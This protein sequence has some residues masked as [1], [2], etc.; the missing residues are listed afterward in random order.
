MR[1]S[2][3]LALAAAALFGA[4]TPASKLLLGSVPPF[5][6]AG[7]LYLG[8]GLATAPRALRGGFVSRIRAL[9]PRNR[10]FVAGSIVFGG[11]LGPVFLLFGL[12]FAKSASVSLWL[13][14][15]L[16]MTALVGQFLFKDRMTRAS[17][18]AAIGI[19]AASL[20]LSFEGGSAGL[21]GGLFVAA[22]CLAWGFDNHFTA[23]NDGLGPEESTFVKGLV[24]GLVNL[25][26]GLILGAH[27]VADF[28]TVL[29]A[30]AIGALSYGISIALYIAA[31]QGLG[32]SRAQLFFS[33]SPIFGI[34]LAA[35][36]LGES[37]TIAQVAAFVV[38]LLS[39]AAL[40]S[41]RHV[42]GHEHTATTHTHWHR[43]GEAH[44]DHVHASLGMF[45]RLFG[46]SHE[47][48]HEAIAHA[49][50]HVSDIHHRHR[51]EGKSA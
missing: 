19:L 36:I 28:R 37:F 5:V 3:L 12:S 10:A 25:A 31:A 27:G 44:H 20:I 41:E 34:G 17:A 48:G 26:I 46:H 33:S 15:E 38:M 1:S 47:H 40:L 23:L 51:H 29:M 39:Y 18:L 50:P 4:A 9:S 13:N 22:A 16:V 42:H 7:L 2:M 6:L 21:E 45:E 43:H 11:I 32:A 35:A 14:L 24:A 49:H 8:A 30:L